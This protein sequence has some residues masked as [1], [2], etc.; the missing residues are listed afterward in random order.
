VPGFALISTTL[1]PLS[2]NQM[3]LTVSMDQVS[4][5]L[6]QELVS[7]SS[8]GEQVIAEESGHFIQWDQPELVIDAIQK[9]VE[10]AR[11]E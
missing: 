8:Q 11:P 2:I 6:Q 7:Q 10:Q 3:L 4:Q 5:G 9:M 1:I